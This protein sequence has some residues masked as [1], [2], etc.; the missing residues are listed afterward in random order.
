MCP[1][2]LLHVLREPVSVEMNL[3]FSIYPWESFFFYNPAV[4]CAVGEEISQILML[5]IAFILLS[6]REFWYKHVECYII[7]F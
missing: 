2:E 1:E 6:I 7:F 5:S 3:C 4:I